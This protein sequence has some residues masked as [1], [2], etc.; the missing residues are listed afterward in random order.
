VSYGNESSA[1]DDFAEDVVDP[2]TIRT[3]GDLAKIVMQVAERAK[4]KADKANGIWRR[5]PRRMDKKRR[6]ALKR[7]AAMATPYRSKSNE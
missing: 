1:T 5:E 4:A 3:Q 6:N 7:A 2:D